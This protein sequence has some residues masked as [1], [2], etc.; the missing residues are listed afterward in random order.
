M[1]VLLDTNVLSEAQ[2]PQAS[3]L[4]LARLAAIPSDDLFLSVVTIGEVTAGIKRLPT[5]RRRRELEEWLAEAVREFAD[6][7]LPVD[8]ETARVWGQV[9]ARAAAGGRVVHAA[10][11]LITA[12][13]IRHGRPLMT[14]I[15]SDFPATGALLIDPW[16]P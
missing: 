16:Q 7:I 14:R 6:R 4:V 12:T 10:D 2:R 1:K 8:V 5:G 11:G 3:P 15:V 9:T 13:A